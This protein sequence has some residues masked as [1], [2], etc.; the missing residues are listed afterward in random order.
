MNGEAMHCYA[1]LGVSHTASAEQIKEK[2]RAL[3]IDARAKLGTGQVS[4]A[5]LERLR[6]AYLVLSDPEKRAQHDREIQAAG[7]KGAPVP[8]AS[9]GRRPVAS[10]QRLFP[11]RGVAATLT[12]GIGLVVMATLWTGMVR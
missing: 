5:A 1:Q 2:Y 3:L 6:E 9:A 4:L 7:A 12:A 8:T 11:A 10:P